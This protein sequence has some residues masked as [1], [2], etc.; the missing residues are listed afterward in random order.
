[1]KYSILLIS[2]FCIPLLGSSQEES[3]H[4]WSDFNYADFTSSKFAYGG[5]AGIRGAISS[6][7]WTVFYIRPKVQYDLKSFLNLAFAASAF[8]TWNTNSP[9]SFEFRLAPEVTAQWPRI[10]PGAFSHRGRYEAR[11]F[12]NDISNDE[13]LDIPNQE[14]NSRFRYQLSFKTNYFNVMEKLDNFF[15]QVSSEFFLPFNET[16]S[17]LFF[18]QNRFVLGIGQ[19]LNDEWSYK[20]DFMW[21]RSK[22]T[23]EGDFSSDE[24][25]V[26]LRVYLKKLD[27]N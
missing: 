13:D 11:F 3:F 8:N 14:H 24:F 5:D 2:F 23:L 12:W 19:L 27:F 21:Q 6:S 7:E 22:N 4:T 15:I 10:N 20:V 1:L 17:E 26:R 25:I 18:N 16:S 9:N